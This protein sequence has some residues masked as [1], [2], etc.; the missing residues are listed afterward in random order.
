[1]PDSRVVW[2]QWLCRGCRCRLSLPCCLSVCF[3]RLLRLPLQPARLNE[4]LDDLMPGLSA[5]V[6]RTY[7]ASVTLE[8]ELENLSVDTPGPEKVLEY[9][10]ANREVAILCNHQ[11]TVPK[12]FEKTWEKMTSREALL[13]RQVEELEAMAKDVK[14]AGGKVKVKSDYEAAEKEAAAAATPKRGSSS[15]SSGAAAGG[16]GAASAGAGAADDEVETAADR[17]KRLKEEEAHLFSKQPSAD[18]VTKRLSAW[19]DKLEKHRLD[20]RNKDENKAVAL[21]TSKINYMDPRITVAWCKRVEL[22]IERVF[23]R[24]LRDKFPWAMG[25]P[26]T[27]KF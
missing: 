25:A 2:A 4:Q 23:P 18:E 13:L 5:K 21:G 16:A 1:M 6:F 24:T 3:S 20:M 22:P 10:R 27:F 15:S 7:N 11:R 9:N 17:V 26:T 14:K 8:R 19:R 12:A